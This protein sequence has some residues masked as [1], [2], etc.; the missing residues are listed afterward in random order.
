M[1]TWL[2]NIQAIITVAKLTGD[3]EL[4]WPSVGGTGTSAG[5]DA[6][7]IPWRDALLA[8]AISNNCAFTDHEALLGGRAAAVAAGA[9]ADSLHEA[10]WFYD[11]QAGNDVLALA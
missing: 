11:L 3:I 4:V 7:R 1:A 5:T 10:A 6:S 9:F 2:A 8:L